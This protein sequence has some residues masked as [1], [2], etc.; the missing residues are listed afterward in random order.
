MHGKKELDKLRKARMRHNNEAVTVREAAKALEGAMQQADVH[1]A[2]KAASRVVTSGW[3]TDRTPELQAGRARVKEVRERQA[4][5]FH[6]HRFLLK[7]RKPQVEGPHPGNNSIE[8]SMVPT[9]AM[10]DNQA[11]GAV[12]FNLVG[13]TRPVPDNYQR[14]AFKLATQPWS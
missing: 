7:K 3:G 8:Q 1:A 4:R 2:I 10:Q 9:S 6:S 14:A 13:T 11:F 12:H 5:A